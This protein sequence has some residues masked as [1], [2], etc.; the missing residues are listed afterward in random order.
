MPDVLQVLAVFAKRA[1]EESL[2]LR[3]SRRPV[4][5]GWATTPVP[6]ATKTIKAKAAMCRELYTRFIFIS[7]F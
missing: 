1:N 7:F 2:D 5:V 6:E 4:L 3:K